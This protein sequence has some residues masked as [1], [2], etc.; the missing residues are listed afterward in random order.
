MHNKFS[1]INSLVEERAGV[2]TKTEAKVLL[3]QETWAL[4]KKAG[5]MAREK[6]RMPV[7]EKNGTIIQL[8][9]GHGHGN[10]NEQKISNLE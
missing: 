1:L 9:T 10:G 2:I 4:I 3:K 5:I 8:S 7:I 6:A